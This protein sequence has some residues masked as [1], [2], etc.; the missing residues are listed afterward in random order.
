MRGMSARGPLEAD[1]CRDYVVPRLKAVGWSEDQVVE[2]YAVADGRPEDG[3]G[4]AVRYATML[5]LPLAYSTNGK[6]S[7]CATSTPVANPV[8]ASR[9][10]GRSPAGKSAIFTTATVP[11]EP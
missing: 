6:G 1:T 11:P 7:G 8:R 3:F 4:Q 9:S 2:Q 5:D 10:R